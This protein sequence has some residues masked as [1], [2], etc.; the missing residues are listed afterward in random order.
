MFE[1]YYTRSNRIRK[2]VTIDF[3]KKLRFQKDLKRTHD[4]MFEN[5]S[6]LKLRKDVMFH[7]GTCIII[8]SN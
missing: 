2:N 8:T 5:I 4:Q 7:Y 1:K 6:R 3:S